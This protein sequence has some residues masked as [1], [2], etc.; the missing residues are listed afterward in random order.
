M[1]VTEHGRAIRIYEQ[2]ITFIEC[3]KCGLPVAVTR[4]QE[5][6]FDEHGLVVYCALGHQTIRRKSDLQEAEE[7]LMDAQSQVRRVEMERDSASHMLDAEIN[8][9][10]KLEKRIHNGVCPHCQRSFV[11]LQRHMKGQHQKKV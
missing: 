9:R 10:R 5:R 6:Q 8:N 1:T 3:F 7:K 11:N 4:H 2:T